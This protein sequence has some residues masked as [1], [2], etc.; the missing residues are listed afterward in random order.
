MSTL[1]TLYTVSAPSGAGKT[2]LVAALLERDEQIQVSVSNTTRTQRPSEVDGVNYYFTPKAQFEAMLKQHAFLEYA[3]V[4]GNYYGTSKQWVEDVLAKGIDV[5]LEIDW[6][7]AAHVRKI[8]PNTVGIFILPPSQEELRSRLTGR[9]QDSDEI[10]DGRMA[11]AFNEIS[12]YG[13]ADFLVVNDSFEEALQELE[14]IVTCHRLRLANQQKRRQQ[15]LVD[16][17]K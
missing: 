11:E 2:S 13:A 15:L 4:F 12:H 3:E 10:I 7:G 1:G 16:L 14:S 9:G 17:L 6:Q 8:L 5:I